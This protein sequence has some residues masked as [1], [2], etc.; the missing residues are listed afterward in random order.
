M[1]LLKPVLQKN[2]RLAYILIGAVSIIV[3]AAITVLASVKLN[4]N[5][6]FNV[7]YFA[8]AN[9]CINATVAVLLIAALWAVRKKNYVLHKKI[10][11][12]AIVLSVLFLISYI[13]QRKLIFRKNK[14]GF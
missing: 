10:M 14:L 11:L 1:P 13:I 5:L 2:D 6:P 8:M 4:V 12:V 7:H 9:A 3:F